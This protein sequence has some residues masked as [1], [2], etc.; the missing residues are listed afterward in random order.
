MGGRSP[1]DQDHCVPRVSLYLA[2][3]TTPL[4]PSKLH[5][6]PPGP[7]SSG[8][9]LGE[10][11]SHIPCSPSAMFPIQDLHGATTG[12]ATPPH[13]NRLVTTQSVYPRPTVP[14]R[15]SLHARPGPPAP[16]HMASL[17]I[18][19]AY[20]H[21]P[22][23]RN[24]HR[25]LAFSFNNQLYFFRALPFGLNVAPFIFTKVLDWPLRTLRIQ[26]INVL[27]YLDDIVLW[28]PS[29]VIL[30]QHVA[31]TVETLSWDFGSTSRSLSWNP[32]R[33]SSGWASSGTHRQD[34][35]RRPNPFGTRSSRLPTSSF[36][37]AA[38]PAGAWR[39]WW[40]S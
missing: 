6:I 16:A 37:E 3:S 26:G 23:R 20:T 7:V 32:K 22:I 25:Y 19:E 34:T 24:L 38:S 35:G 4:T 11:G 33:P 9:G 13:Y 2:R 5:P 15:Q 31:R 17:D 36:N 27:A 29:P 8:P 14:S 28:H 30:R 1:I 21:I 40:V 18:S 10:E 12:W 39:L